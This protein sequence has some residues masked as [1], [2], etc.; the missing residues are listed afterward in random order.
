MINKNKF[1]K[2]FF[3]PYVSE[4]SSISSEKFN[5]IV[6]KVPICTTKVE[7]KQA[8]Q[9]LFKVK[10]NRVNTLIIQGKKKRKN[11]HIGCLSN[12]KKAY[13]SLEKGQDINVI[14]QVE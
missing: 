10:V 4:K 12:W 6:V 9:T 8:V 3:S 1:L 13:I 11:G 2:M 5:T 14:G 7:I